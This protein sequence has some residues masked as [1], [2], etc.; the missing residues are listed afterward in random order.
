MHMGYIQFEDEISLAEVVNLI[1]IKKMQFRM[2]RDMFQHVT[3]FETFCCRIGVPHEFKSVRCDD[4]CDL[5]EGDADE[6]SV[7]ADVF[8]ACSTRSSSIATDLFAGSW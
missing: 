4:V 6:T 8:E 3:D 1:G 5:S 7:R 2:A